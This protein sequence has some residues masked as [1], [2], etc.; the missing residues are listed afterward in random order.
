LNDGAVRTKHFDIKIVCRPRL[1]SHCVRWG[2]SS[3]SPKSGTA[4][5]FLAHVSCGQ[6]AGWIKMPLGSPGDIVLDGDPG[7]PKTG[8]QHTPMFGSWL[9]W[10]GTAGWIR[11][12]LVLR[13]ERGTA[14][15]PPLF[16]PLC[17]GTVADLSNC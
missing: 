16:G 7:H 17:S 13:P 12:H 10:P 1:T 3:P 9:L 14:A 15:L 2:L 5:Q 4:V 11:C 6:T 8:A